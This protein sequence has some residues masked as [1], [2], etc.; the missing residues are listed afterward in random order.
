MVAARVACV[1]SLGL[2][3][4]A[5]LA[6]TDPPSEPAEPAPA[7]I[8]ISGKRPGP[9]LW[10]VSK[11]GH[12]MWVVGML[13]P[14]P[15]KMEWDDGRVE[16]LVGQSQEVLGPP[17]TGVGVGWLGGL[18]ALAALPALVGMKKNPDGA[19][20][21]DVLPADVYA[22]W[23]VLKQKY[24][25]EDD[26]VEG[27]RPFF[28]A[29]ELMD[30]GLKK[31][32]LSGGIEV[33]RQIEGIA[34]KRGVKLT[35][36]GFFVQLDDPGA[37]L[38]EFK[39]SQMEDT[40]CFTKT[41]ERFEGDIEAMRTRAKAWAEGNIAEISSLDYAERDDAC[42][43]AVLNSPAARKHPAF[44]NLRERR[45]ASWLK[46]AEKSL[47]SNAS[48]VAMLS[49]SDILGPKSYLAALQA[50]GYTVESPK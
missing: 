48:T 43:D 41:L 25:G 37:V 14:L 22:R 34:K 12:V 9:G 28:A 39:K 40:A 44:Q 18:K 20:L 24:I 36:T 21:H 16:R 42:N 11:D 33:R 35:D 5:A 38:K 7:Q 13:A 47:D 23:G 31:S 2:L 1:L 50:R 30:A 4:A 3:S 45:L 32:G 49:M 6:Q 10:K 17:G 27:Y 15:Q 46:A 8:L 29:Q 19:R 26:G